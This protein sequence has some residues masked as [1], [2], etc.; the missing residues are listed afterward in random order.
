ME[1]SNHSHEF[2]DGWPSSSLS[3]SSDE[4]AESEIEEVVQDPGFT[5]HSWNRIT[6]RSVDPPDRHH[7]L[8][9]ASEARSD[10]N[11]T[12]LLRHNRDSPPVAP[13]AARNPAS[14]R[15]LPPLNASS[16]SRSRS[17]EILLGA[18][19]TTRDLPSS[20]LHL[21]SFSV[22]DALPSIDALPPISPTASQSSYDSWPGSWPSLTQSE[23]V[24]LTNEAS[25]P[26]MPPTTRTK[27]RASR[28][29]PSDAPSTAE[30]SNK[31]RKTALRGEGRE[32]M[33]KEVIDPAEVDLTQ[34]NDDNSL[35]KVLETQQEMAIKAQREEQGDKPV[36]FSGLQCIICLETMTNITATHCG[37][38]PSKSHW[39]PHTRLTYCYVGH[40]FCHTCLMESLVAGE[41]QEQENGKSYSRCPVCRKKVTRPK[42]GKDSQQIIPLEI[43]FTT[44]NQIATDKLKV[45]ITS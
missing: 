20:H 40:L 42:A 10:S 29:I 22:P 19:P 25:P 43:K 27:R 32:K 18:L 17:D 11:I 41:Q 4:D 36:R 12:S 34:V 38:P 14:S 7:R 3:P 21:P 16:F 24:D 2:S 5:E 8:M 35:D 26:T 44:T 15:T 1:E 28:S 13:P 9:H 31:R 39:K 37:K 45:S 23:F 33:M 30:S 6:Q